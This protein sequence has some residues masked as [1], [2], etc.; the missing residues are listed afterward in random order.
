MVSKW[1]DSLAQTFHFLKK[2][3]SGN[4]LEYIT[5]FLLPIHQKEQKQNPKVPAVCF[6]T[7]LF[8]F[9]F[10]K[11]SWCS[12]AMLCS[13]MLSTVRADNRL[14]FCLS[15]TTF[16]IKSSHTLKSLNMWARNVH[17]S[18][19]RKGQLSS[20][21]TELRGNCEGGKHT[22]IELWWLCFWRIYSAFS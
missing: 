12:Q 6:W 8:Q 16:S 5:T 11:I 14:S 22:G 17:W 7:E 10:I 19:K 4:F 2:I 3:P 15:W 1:T 13:S 9:P 20:F 21:I 18:K